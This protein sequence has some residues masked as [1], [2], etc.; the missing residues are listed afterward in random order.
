MGQYTD[1]KEEQEDRLKHAM[2]DPEIQRI[3]QDPQIHNFLQ[4]MQKNPRDPAVLKGLQDPILSAKLQKLI[5]A[6]VLKTGWEWLRD[7]LI[8]I[9]WWYKLNYMSPSVVKNS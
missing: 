3:L 8:L 5:A 1:T 7:Y 2:A 9:I 4:D 6:G